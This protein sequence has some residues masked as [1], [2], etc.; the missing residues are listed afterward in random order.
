[1]GFCK[2]PGP[3]NKRI[4]E[5]IGE[6]KEGGQKPVCSKAG[7]K[8]GEREGKRIRHKVHAEG[9]GNSGKKK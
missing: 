5:I 1:M 2:N 3:P 7:G 6:V 8:S 4:G 9:G